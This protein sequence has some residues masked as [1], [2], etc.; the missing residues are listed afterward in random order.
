MFGVQMNQS[1]WK[2]GQKL[3]VRQRNDVLRGDDEE[4]ERR[5]VEKR[6]KGNNKK[7]IVEQF[8]QAMKESTTH[9]GGRSIE[10]TAVVGKSLKEVLE[11]RE[12]QMKDIEQL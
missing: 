10:E 3:L 11:E 2:R 6:K 7:K 12:V 9:E 1:S 4:D 8:L 5:D